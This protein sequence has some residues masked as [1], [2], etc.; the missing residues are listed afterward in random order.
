MK[1][2]SFLLLSVAALVLVAVT[3]QAALLVEYNFEGNGNATAGLPVSTAATVSGGNFTAAGK[4]GTNAGAVTTTSGYINVNVPTGEPWGTNN[5]G[6]WSGSLSFWINAGASG[7]DNNLFTTRNGAYNSGINTGATDGAALAFYMP[8]GP[9]AY[10]TSPATLNNTWHLIT[11]TWTATTGTGGTGSAAFY[12]DGEQYD[13]VSNVGTATSASAYTAGGATV[14]GDDVTSGGVPKTGVSIVGSY[15]DYA[16]WNNVLSAT[17][18]KTMYNLG[19]SALN[20]GAA[21]A[22]KLFDLFAAGS[23]TALVGGQTWAPATG[24][25]GTAATVSANYV[26]LDGAGGGVQVVPEPGTLSLLLAGAI[27]LLVF[28]WRKRK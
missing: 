27:G 19:N 10:S 23:G 20:Y 14:L 22:Q 5:N 17:E 4:I 25:A 12:V 6:L 7:T 3:S 9:Y 24:L 26:V 28:A 11:A 16:A 2:V 18:V 13:S 21:D 1:K 8:G 15:D